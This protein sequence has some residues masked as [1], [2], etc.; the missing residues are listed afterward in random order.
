MALRDIADRASCRQDVTG[1]DVA[2]VL[3]L[4]ASIQLAGERACG[5]EFE[6]WPETLNLR[7]RG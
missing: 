7:N 6:A 4:G 5:L 3:E 1:N 2:E